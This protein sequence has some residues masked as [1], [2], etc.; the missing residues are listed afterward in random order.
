MKFDVQR[1]INEYPT[2][3]KEFRKVYDDKFT[4]RLAHKQ[5]KWVYLRTRL[6]EAQNW[7]CCFCGVYMTEVRGKNNSVTVE[8]VTPKSMGGTDHH[9]NL[10]ASCNRCNNSR[11]TKDVTKFVPPVEN[12]KSNAM[13]RLEA[14]VRKYVKKAQRFSEIDFK[15]ND[16]IQS[17]DDWFSTLSLCAKG[18]K[19]FFSEYKAA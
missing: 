15:V 13:V 10:A 12:E 5:S 6:A 19:M 14:K 4:A 16:N 8:H 11:G 2:D 9:D 18:K 3:V 1:I 17:F 7:K